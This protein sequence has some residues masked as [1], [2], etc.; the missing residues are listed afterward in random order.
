MF[1][2]GVGGFA[3]FFTIH[4]VIYF[5]MISKWFVKVSPTFKKFTSVVRERRDW[6]MPFP[7]AL[8]WNEVHLALFRIWTWDIKSISH[9][10]NYYTMSMSKDKMCTWEFRVKVEGRTRFDLSS[11]GVN[12]SLIDQAYKL[13][14]LSFKYS[15]MIGQVLFASSFDKCSVNLIDCRQY[16]Q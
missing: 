13:R 3:C 15:I 2:I 11:V 1:F 14:P 8:A 10:D 5:E 12:I 16:W 6:F 9:D 7:R 4:K